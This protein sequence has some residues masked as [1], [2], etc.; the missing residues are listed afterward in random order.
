M[1]KSNL[2]K[3]LV[4]IL[5]F[6]VSVCFTVGCNNAP[7][8]GNNSSNEQSANSSV[9]AHVHF[10]EEA[11]CST[12]KTCAVCG[13]TEGEPNGH[14]LA[15][16]QAVAP[17]CT[18]TGL[19]EGKA[20]S[21]CGEVLV[22]QE[23]IPALG[24]TEVI[25]VAVEA[26]C[27]KTGLTEGSH[28]SVC[29]EV[30]IAQETVP[31]LGHTD[32]NPKDYTC[33][34][35]E[36]DLCTNHE[37]EIL[38]EVK[39]TCESTGL[40]AGKKCSICGEIL[41][42]QETVP[43]LGHTE[44]IDKAV[45]ATCT[46]TGLTEG[47][48]CSVC[49]EVLIAQ[50]IVPALGHT[51]V[52]PKDYTCDVCEEDLC[53]NHE[54]EILSEVKPTC[55]STGLTAGKKCSICG[56]ILVA[57]EVVEALG[58]TEVVDSAVSP[59]CV[60]TGL[61]E[62]KHCSVCGEILLAQEVVE[63]LGHTE[64][65]DSAVSPSCVN[66]GL[67]EGK[68]CSVCD[69]ILVEQ[70]VVEALGHTEVVDSAVSPNCINTGLTE[71]KHCSVCGE[72]LVEQEIISA[73]G[74]IE[75]VD[76]E[77]VEATCTEAGFTKESHCLTCGEVLSIQEE[78]SALGHVLGGWIIDKESTT[79]EAGSKH[80]ECNVCHEI[81]Q[82]EV[83]LRKQLSYTVNTNGTTCTVTGIG[84]YPDKDLIIPEN[85]DGY[86]VTAIGKKA[87]YQN[88]SITSVVIPDCVTEVSDEAFAFCSN[89][90]SAVIG[91]GVT[92]I[93]YKMFT[94]A[95]SL[96]SVTIKGAVT[97]IGFDAFR[98]CSLADGFV[99]PATV[100][101]IGDCAFS[102]SGLKSIV[103]PKSVSEIFSM[104]SGLFDSC[105]SLESVVFEQGSSMQEIYSDMFRGCISLKEIILPDSITAI[106]EW[107]FYN[108]DSLTSVV[109][110]DS[111]TSIGE[112]AFYGCGGLKDIY[113]KGTVSAWGQITIGSRNEQLQNGKQYFYLE[114]EPSINTDGTG[115]VGD[116]WHYSEDGVMNVWDDEEFSKRND[117]AY[118]DGLTFGFLEDG[119]CYVADYTGTA[120]SV[121]IPSMYLGTRVTTIGEKAF[122][123]CYDVTSITIPDTVISI[124]DSAFYYCRSLKEIVLSGNNT[125][126][127]M[128]EGNLYSKD[129][130]TFIQYLL[131]RGGESFTIPSTVTCIDG[132]AF[133]GCSTLTKVTIPNGVQVSVGM[134]LR[135]VTV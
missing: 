13:K 11:T 46:K 128:E 129:K 68:H 38:S 54:E 55:E 73:L 1:K 107:A 122:S 37:E 130:T 9:D 18:K 69:T 111:V 5:T 61:T 14:I 123:G 109:I 113:Y 49:N 118:T 90:K 103:I 52:N 43:A 124:S 40:T 127:T 99:I 2:I 3:L 6:L 92:V 12:P 93:P 78:I 64:V 95:L 106:G 91:E 35:C 47:K 79:E 70:E 81:L 53:T 102:E 67:T 94:N 98:R 19:T 114:V 30:L 21:V 34:V 36:E 108:C 104:F 110:P 44:V 80:K 112:W 115:Y 33:D 58:H 51:D 59:S 126:F 17:T 57:Q 85:I 63:A 101:R 71:G 7:S 20:C 82:T 45:E 132:Y 8:G 75:V 10:W 60:N 25:D 133:A 76:K 86:I 97:S 41:V 26:T 39:P 50:E 4:L 89:V 32:V 117:V 88:T 116:Y 96:S 15:T 72:V 22:A 23:T 135:I 84:G 28:C 74:H 83:V 125:A 65:V 66:T 77:A 120:V 27:T 134:R 31:A 119:S 16:V 62:G 121:T 24:H 131:G 29:N 87:F 56:E 48:T 100:T 105:A 42:A